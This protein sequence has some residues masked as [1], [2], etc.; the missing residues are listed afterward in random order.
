M[1]YLGSLPLPLPLFLL[2]FSASLLL[3]IGKVGKA[4]LSIPGAI[5]A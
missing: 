1:C 2:V 4:L 3:S 5:S